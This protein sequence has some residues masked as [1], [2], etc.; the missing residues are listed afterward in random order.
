ML[1]A[2]P[3]FQIDGNFGFTSGLAEML[4]Q[5]HDGAI[6]LLPAVPDV[7]K[8]GKVTG[9]RARGG[10]VVESLEWEDGKLQKA[11]IRSTIGGNL[12]LRSYTPIQLAGK[13]KLKKARG[14]NDNSFYQ[15]PTIAEPLISEKAELKGLTLPQSYLYDIRMKAGDVMTIIGRY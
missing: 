4:M 12:R 7:W 1:D 2:H 6:H 5:S 3:P 8:D 15:T 11:V 10:F 13:G 14:A 9:L